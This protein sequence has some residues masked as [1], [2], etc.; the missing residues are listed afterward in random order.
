M[1]SQDVRKFTP[2]SY[3]T[4]ALWGCC[5]AFTPHLQLITPSRAFGTANHVQSLDDFY[6]QL[7]QFS[8][9]TVVLKLAKK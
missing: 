6:S 1:P 2:V 7:L 9:P 8:V 4:S 5:P 3:R